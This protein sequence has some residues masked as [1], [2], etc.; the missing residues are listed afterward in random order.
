MARFPNLNPCEPTFGLYRG[1]TVGR[2][3]GRRKAA[4]IPTSNSLYFPP[5]ASVNTEATVA[6]P[7][8]KSPSWLGP[9]T[10]HP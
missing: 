3:E 5:L 1:G 6:F 10:D 8:R 2:A 9:P 7:M 4:L